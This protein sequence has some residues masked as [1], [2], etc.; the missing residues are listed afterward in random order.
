MIAHVDKLQMK[1]NVSI[2][3]HTAIGMA[4]HAQHLP[5]MVYHKLI[6]LN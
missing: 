4:N 3:L 6:A 1:M 2:C 5:V